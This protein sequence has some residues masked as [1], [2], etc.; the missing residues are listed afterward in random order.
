MD[1]E[2]FVRTTLTTITQDMKKVKDSQSRTETRLDALDKR[3]ETNESDIKDLKESV[4][5]DSAIVTA[6]ETKC[7][8][9]NSII[10]AKDTELQ[11]MRDRLKA[12]ETSTL[13]LERYTRGFNVRFVNIPEEE[14]EDC[15]SKLNEIVK[16]KFGI[17]N[18]IENAHRSGKKKPGIPRHIIARMYSR[19]TRRR[20]ITESRQNPGT[21]RIIDD[22][23][24]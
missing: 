22:L 12:V 7:K 23:P 18:A 17:E 10:T 21:F 14:D 4:Q 19:A 6:N 8:E 3:I 15:I 11:E 1:F 9:L 13:S 24:A 5:F 20:I 2:T 16:T